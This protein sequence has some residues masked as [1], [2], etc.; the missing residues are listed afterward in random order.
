[1][2]SCR[3]FPFAHC[4]LEI[5]LFFPFSSS[6]FFFPSPMHF[7]KLYFKLLLKWASIGPLFPKIV[8]IT[9]AKIVMKNIAKGRRLGGK[10]RKRHILKGNQ[11][12]EEGSSTE[13]VFHSRA[14]NLRADFS[15]YLAKQIKQ[16]LKMLLNF[17]ADPWT[18]DI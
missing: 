11:H 3:S 9:T 8:T 5:S 7:S 12:L 2:P 14:S 15:L 13:W 16:H 10:K 6:S 4:L 18:I 17:L 1:M